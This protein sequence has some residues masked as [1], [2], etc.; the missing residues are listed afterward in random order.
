M[1]QSQ[2]LQEGFNTVRSNQHMLV[3]RQ[4][5]PGIGGGCKLLAYCQ[6]INLKMGYAFLP[7]SDVG[8]MFVATGGDG[9][10]ALTDV[11]E[12]GWRVAWMF[13]QTPVLDSFELLFRRHFAIVVQDAQSLG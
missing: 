3:V 5:A 11:I 9:E 4:N 7:Q 8:L 6:Q 2:L 12:M 1:Q 13:M 10:L